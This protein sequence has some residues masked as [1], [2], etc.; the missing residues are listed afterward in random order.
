MLKSTAS[1]SA[2]DFVLSRATKTESL[3]PNAGHHRCSGESR[4]MSFGATPEHRRGKLKKVLLTAAA[5]AV[6]L[7]IA[8]A[9]IAHHYWPFTESAVRADLASDASAN[10]RFGSFHQT[11]F[12]PGCV[13]ENVVFQ[14]DNST[15]PLI[16]IRRLTIRS[17]LGGLLHN[18]VSLVRAEGMHVTLARSDFAQNNSNGQQST[19]DRLVADDAVLEIRR[20]DPQQSLRFVFHQFAMKNLGGTGPVAFSAVFDNPMPAGLLRTSGQFGPWNRSHA[21]QTPVSG[22]YSLEQADMGVFEGIGGII[23]SKGDFSGTF[24]EINLDGS[25]ITPEFEIKKTH[26]SLPLETD[27]TATVD[28]DNGNVVLHQVKARFGH[29]DI[30]AQGTIGPTP[31]GKRAAIL[32][33]RCDRG[34]IEDV[35]YPFIHSPRSPLNGDVVFTMKVTIPSGHEPFLQKLDLR[36]DFQIHNAR[37]THEQTQERLNNIAEKPGQKDATETLAD[38]QGKVEVT[39]GVAHFS[40]L[41]VHDQ[42]A[43]AV[44]KG[45]FGLIDERVKM[46]GKLK[47]AASLTKTTH[48]VSSVFAKVLEPFFKKKPHVNVVPVKIG[49]TYKHPSF[50]LDLNSKM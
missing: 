28:A 14:R 48:G 16:T 3:N 4:M 7:V 46:Y 12:P 20:S 25:T 9:A 19:V 49:G 29:N 40:Y 31:G 17:Y 15:E 8:G 45:S 11:Y 22:K 6:P 50:G 44:F 41:S 42:D 38:F 13:A 5:I 33:L 47:T 43:A 27:F 10:V 32:D 1:N 39:N 21:D 26:H 2:F 34:R 37:F 18:H 23:S 24:K 36:S 30:V 35:F